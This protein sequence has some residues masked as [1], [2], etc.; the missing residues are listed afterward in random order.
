MSSSSEFNLVKTGVLTVS[1]IDNF[2][3]II[4]RGQNDEWQGFEVDVLQSFAKHLDLQ[5]AMKIVTFDGIWTLPKQGQCDI[6]AA[7]LSIAKEHYQVGA[8]FTEPY[9]FIKQSF[10]VKNVENKELTLAACPTKIGDKA[11]QQERIPPEF[12]LVDSEDT[13]EK[14]AL[15]VADDNPKLLALLNQHI[16]SLRKA[17]ELAKFYQR[18]CLV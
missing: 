3:P 17:G 16:L 2:R 8:A 15:V 1:T 6:A 14:F 11:L 5:L 10:L 7:G 9:L 18:W 13:D 4:F 12:T